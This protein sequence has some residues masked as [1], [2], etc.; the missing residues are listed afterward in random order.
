M[1]ASTTVIRVKMRSA[2]NVERQSTKRLKRGIYL[3]NSGEIRGWRL[4][5]EV[6]LN[7]PKEIRAEEQKLLKTT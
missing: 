2:Y 3:G 1:L 7:P 5:T 6:W 4:V